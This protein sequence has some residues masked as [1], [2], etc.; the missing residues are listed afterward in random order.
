MAVTENV[1]QN[2]VVSDVIS[3]HR[4]LGSA[5]SPEQIREVVIEAG[6][7]VGENRVPKSAVVFLVCC[8][9]MQLAFLKK[10]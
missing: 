1:P 7:F 8:A 9:Q 5:T 4:H 2:N 3:L 10:K 6:T